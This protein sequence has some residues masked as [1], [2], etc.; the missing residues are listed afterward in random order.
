MLEFTNKK[1]EQIA[2]AIGYEDPNSFR[3]VLYRVMGL[4]PGISPPFR[5][6]GERRPKQTLRK[7]SKN[8]R[9]R[10]FT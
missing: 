8:V 5:R 3:K 6:S 4:S 1:I 9:F 2:W 10:P 7:R